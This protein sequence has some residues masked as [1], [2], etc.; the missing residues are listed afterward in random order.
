MEQS[1]YNSCLMLAAE[2]VTP[3]SL[4]SIF[5]ESDLNDTGIEFDSHVTIFYAGHKFID[6][7]NLYKDIDELDPKFLIWLKGQKNVYTPVR[8]LFDLGKFEN[9]SDYVILELRHDTDAYEK[10]SGLNEKLMSHYSLT[11]DFGDYKPHLS[12]AEL[13]SGLADKYILDKRLMKVLDDSLVRFEDLVLSY[14]QDG[15]SEYKLH[16]ITHWNSVERFFRVRD[17]RREM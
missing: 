15:V 10:I 6:K 8:E 5:E 2:L 14:G 17:L 11:S 9:T 4:S 12:L 16:D 13:E 1:G 7:V 3:V